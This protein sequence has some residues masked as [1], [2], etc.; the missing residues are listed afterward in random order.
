MICEILISKFSKAKFSFGWVVVLLSLSFSLNST[1]CNAMEAPGPRLS[2]GNIL[3]GQYPEIL[4]VGVT[5]YLEKMAKKYGPD[6]TPVKISMGP[7]STLFVVSHPDDIHQIL[8]G[9]LKDKF[10]KGYSA[11]TLSD[12]LLGN[13]VGVIETNDIYRSIKNY[14]HRYLLQRGVKGYFSEMVDQSKRFVKSLQLKRASL[15]GEAIDIEKEVT[16]F[17]IRNVSNSMFHFDIPYNKEGDEKADQIS[18]SIKTV[19]DFIAYKI[20]IPFSMPLFI[21]TQANRDYKKSVEQIKK[22]VSEMI[23]NDENN[24][25]VDGNEA[26]DTLLRALQNAQENGLPDSTDQSR[27]L[28]FTGND[29]YDQVISIFFAGHDTTSH[30]MTMAIYHLFQNPNVREKLVAELR[31]KLGPSMELQGPEQLSS[32]HLPYLDSFLKEVLRL[33]S[34]VPGIARDA[35]ETVSLRGYKIS[36]G[37]S[38]FLSF[39]SLHRLN[40]YWDNPNTFDP[41]RFMPNNSQI[42]RPLRSFSPFGGGERKCMGEFFAMQEA[43]ILMVQLLASDLHFQLVENAKIEPVFYCTIKLANGLPM[44][45]SQY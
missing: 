20:T 32:H 10:K 24:R 35:Q 22:I 21:N 18:S 2:Y 28:P 25:E 34:P 14:M 4:K 3:W 38:V 1:L 16:A 30:L 29:L 33:D 43:K 45:L 40:S 42:K 39:N 41:E 37:S 9:D 23:V 19:L 27:V 15:N 17:A 13:G 31:E 11:K 26:N 6:G 7:L 36:K 44:V 12:Y 8:S 5:F